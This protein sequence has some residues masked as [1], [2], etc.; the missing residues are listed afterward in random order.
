MEQ[1][2]REEESPH[3]FYKIKHTSKSIRAIANYYLTLI[4]RGW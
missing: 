4:Y 1:G 3:H 2:L